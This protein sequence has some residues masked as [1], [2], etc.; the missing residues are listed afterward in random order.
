MKGLT[1]PRGTPHSQ[2]PLR[3][4]QPAFPLQTHTL[5]L[6]R[7]GPAA[8][9]AAPP[10]AEYDTD[11]FKAQAD[12]GLKPVVASTGSLTNQGD[13]EQHQVGV[14]LVLPAP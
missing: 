7:P 3:Y 12:Q 10:S 6:W 11:A 2:L 1:H 14:A 4:P 5:T 13:T 8:A 9:A